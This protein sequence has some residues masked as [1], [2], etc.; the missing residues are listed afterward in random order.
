[1]ASL[2]TR[3]ITQDAHI[4]T[5]IGSAGENIMHVSSL[6]PKCVTHTNCAH[7]VNGGLHLLTG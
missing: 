7:T 5:H 1:M 4:G 3:L 6:F 2:L